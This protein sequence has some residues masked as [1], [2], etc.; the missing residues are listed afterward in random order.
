MEGEVETRGGREEGGEKWGR[1]MEGKKEEREIGKEGGREGG[2]E[3]CL[4]L[5]CVIPTEPLQTL[6]TTGS[7]LTGSQGIHQVGVACCQ[8]SGAG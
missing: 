7:L 1:R 6:S 2:R 3:G 4:L 5:S 8:S